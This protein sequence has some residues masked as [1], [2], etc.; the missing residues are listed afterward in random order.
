[1]KTKRVLMNTIIVLG[2]VM[3]FTLAKNGIMDATTQ[4]ALA[5]RD[6]ADGIVLNA[7]PFGNRTLTGFLG[8]FIGYCEI[9]T[10]M[11]CFPVMIAGLLSI[12][13]VLLRFTADNFKIVHRKKRM[14]RLHVR[15]RCQ[16]KNNT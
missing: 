12:V 8:V 5:I 6:V 13:A 2:C 10:L 11:I 3:L 4:N 1:M 9:F 16:R 14:K 7:V 15:Q